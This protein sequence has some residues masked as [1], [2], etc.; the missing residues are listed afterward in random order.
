MSLILPKTFVNC[1]SRLV[2]KTAF[3]PTDIPNLILWLDGADPNGTGVQP[4][5]GTAIATWT[6]K[7]GQGNNV[8]QSTGAN[9]PLF[10]TNQ[11]NGK[12]GLTFD[13]SNDSFTCPAAL[14]AIPNGNHTLFIVCKNNGGA[15]QYVIRGA[16]LGSDRFY[17]RY[18]G[19]NTVGFLNR[20]GS[21]NG[22]SIGGVTKTNAN[23]FTAFLEGT[24]Q[25]LAVNNGTPTTN[26]S[27]EYEASISSLNISDSFLLNG[28][29]FAIL[30]FSRSLSDTEK[31]R[32]NYYLSNELGIAI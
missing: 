19:A 31:F 7:S 25:S 14:R 23:I 13:G 22:I 9:Q 6:D 10:Q 3:R 26:A 24:T 28:A 18:E 15:S 20:T 4:A 30:W 1:P 11:Q 32:L 27:G 17:F 21:A 2:A 12:P 8:T 5:N 29:V 16:E